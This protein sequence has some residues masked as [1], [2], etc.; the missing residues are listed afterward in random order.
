MDAATSFPLDAYASNAPEAEG[1]MPAILFFRHPV[2]HLNIDVY[3]IFASP[4]G[5]KFFIPDSLQ[6]C[7][8]ATLSAGTDQ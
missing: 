1:V 4:H 5:F 2:I 3:S 8:K 7:R 6:I